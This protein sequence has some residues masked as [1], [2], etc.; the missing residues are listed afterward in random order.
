VKKKTLNTLNLMQWVHNVCKQITDQTIYQHMPKV[1]KA[2]IWVA[3]KHGR[4][5]SYLVTR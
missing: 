5:C 4:F 1:R 3:R 2:N